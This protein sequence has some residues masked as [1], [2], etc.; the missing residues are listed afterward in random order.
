MVG[1]SVVDFLTK[2]PVA[3]M[4]MF[5]SLDLGAT[6]PVIMTSESS[7]IP[8]SPLIPVWSGLPVVSTIWTDTMALWMS[9][10]R[11]QHASQGVGQ[12]LHVPRSQEMSFFGSPRTMMA[13]SFMKIC[14]LPRAFP[15]NV[16]VSPEEADLRMSRMSIGSAGASV[17]RYGDRDM[18]GA[19]AFDVVFFLSSEHEA[20]MM[21]SAARVSLIRFDGFMVISVRILVGSESFR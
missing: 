10:G 18:E 2:I 16:T 6:M 8:P 19:S 5:L 15:E 3:L 11:S 17:R 9:S 4:S 1:Y 21:E 7:L 20:R 13:R 14:F 12:P